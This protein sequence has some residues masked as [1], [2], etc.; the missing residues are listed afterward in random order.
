MIESDQVLTLAVRE[1]TQCDGASK[2]KMGGFEPGTSRSRVDCLIHS[3]TAPTAV[4]TIIQK[5]SVITTNPPSAILEIGLKM[6]IL[7]R[8]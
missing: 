2:W 5:L 1:K 7:S 4:V 6:L 3:A 8:L